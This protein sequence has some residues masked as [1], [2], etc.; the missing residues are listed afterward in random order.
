MKDGQ[1][2]EAGG[3]THV[4]T[5]PV[6]FTHSTSHLSPLSYRVWAG[7]ETLKCELGTDPPL[8]I[9]MSTRITVILISTQ[10]NTPDH[11]KTQIY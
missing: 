8:E 3:E 2:E 1:A 9:V 10:P 7:L 5:N 4:N 11:Q 6:F